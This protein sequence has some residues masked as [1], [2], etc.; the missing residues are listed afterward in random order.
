MSRNPEPAFDANGKRVPVAKREAWLSKIPENDL[1]KFEGYSCYTT[2]N[3]GFVIYGIKQGFVKGYDR[4]TRKH[5]VYPTS[6]V[7]VS[8]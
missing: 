7:I 6:E 8:L 3:H 5:E 1:K 4:V 2:D